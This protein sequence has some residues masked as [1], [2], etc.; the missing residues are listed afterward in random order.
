MNLINQ[1]FQELYPGQ[2]LNK[3]IQIKYSGK[4]K[5]YN[6]NV[7]YT[8]EFIHFN[9]SKE[10]KTVSKEIQI[11]LIQSLMVKIFKGQPN[12]GYRD[13]Y[14]SFIKNLSKY[15]TATKVDPTLQQS[16][17]RVNNQYFDSLMDLPNLEWGSASTSKLG[18]YEYQ[19][20]TISISTIFQDS[21][22]EILDYIMYHEML[23][24]KFQFKSSNRGRSL[25]HSNEFKKAEKQFQNVHKVESNLK[26]LLRKSKIKGSFFSF[27]LK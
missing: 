3:A 20:N 10:W 25:H 6:A 2:E 11:G 27:L 13:L 9:L 14:E 24:K 8:N 16:F 26:A 7:R 12:T 22:E 23:H 4:F 1:A 17:E 15:T 18:S 19:T 21:E 5:P